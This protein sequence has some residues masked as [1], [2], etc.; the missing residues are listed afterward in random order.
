[1]TQRF[2]DRGNRGF[3]L[4]ETLTVVAIL[5]ILL[6]ISAVAAFHYRDYLKITELDNAAR[7]IYMA[8]ENRA[9][10]LGGSGQLDKALG[11]DTARPLAEGGGE[12]ESASVYFAKD[13]A[14]ELGLLTGDAI[15]RAL[16]EGSFYIVYDRSSGAV[17]DVFYTEGPEIQTIDDAFDLAAQGRDARMR[18]PED[19]PMLGYYGGEQGARKPY[20]PLPAPEVMV[21]IHNEERLTVDV[22]FSVPDDAK[23]AVAGNW[24]HNSEQTVTLDCGG[25]EITLLSRDTNGVTTFARHFSTSSNAD[26]SSVTYTWILDALDSSAEKRHFRQ[27]FTDTSLTFGG[28][29]TVTAEIELSAPGRRPTSASGSDTNNSLFAERS[30]GSVARLENL[31]HLQNLDK[32]TSGVAGKTSAVQVS[33]I[34]CRG[35]E[36]LAIYYPSKHEFTPIENDELLSFDAGWAA[37]KTGEADKETGEAAGK[38]GEADQ[39]TKKEPERRNE[40]TDLK[41]TAA[42]ASGKPGAGLFAKT[43]DGMAFTGV[44]L[45]G[46]EV[47]AGGA[48]A[49]GSVPAA[50]ALVGAAGSGAAF[51]DIRVVNSKVVGSGPAGGVAG[52]VANGTNSFSDCWVYWEPEEGQSNLRS[53]LGSD[54]ENNPYKFDKIIR[55]TS[56]GGL[57]GKLSGTTTI[58]KSL[59]STLVGGTNAGGLVG[60]AAQ[61]VVVNT[62]YADCYLKGT[63]AAAGLLGVCG[64]SELSNVYTAGFI[65][66]D[67]MTSGSVGGIVSGTHGTVTGGNV[68]TAVA[69]LN[70]KDK[71]ETELGI[72]AKDSGL[73]NCYYLSP[74]ATT[75]GEKPTEN[76]AVSYDDMSTEKLFDTAMGDKFAFKKSAGDTHPYNLQEKEELNPPYSFPGLVG[77]P[78]YGDWRAYFK[79]PSLVYYE[80]DSTGKVGFSGGNARE[81]IGKLNTGVKVVTDGYAV[82]LM[83]DDLPKDGEFTVEYTYVGKNGVKQNFEE[84]Y[85]ADKENNT[86][87]AQTSGATLPLASWKRMEGGEEKEYKYWLAPLPEELVIGVK[88]T[89]TTPDGKYLKDEYKSDTSK[90]FYQYLRIDTDI[91]LKNEKT[92]SGEYFYNPHFAETVRPYVPETEGA[93]PPDWTQSTIQ[94]YITNTLIPVGAPVSVS[95]R[96]PRHFYHLSQYEDYY[97]NARLAFQQGLA[98]DGKK[99]VYKGYPGLLSYGSRDFQLQSPI[100]TQDKPFLGT[101]NGDSLPIRRL[102]FELPENEKNRVSAGLFGTSNGRLRNIVYSLDPRENPNDPNE[103][104]ENKPRS[105]LFQNS[106]LETYLGAL[107][108]LNGLNGKIENCAV[109]GVNLTTQVFS[110][111]IY[112]GGLCGENRGSI[113]NSAAECARLH[114]EGSNYASAYVGGLTGRNSD[115]INTSYA[116]GCLA[117]TASQ[118]NAPAYLAGFV[119]INA[120]S[121]SNSYAAMHLDTDGVSAQARGFCAQTSG[122][123]QRKTFYLNEGNFSYRGEQFL[124][125]YAEG[126]GGT[127]Q[128]ISYIDL[129]AADSPVPDMERKSGEG[130]FPYPTGVKKN[131]TAEHY[132][133]WPKPLELGS[134]GVYYWEELQLPGKEGRSYCVSLLAVNPGKTQDSPKTISKISTLS[135]AHDEGGEVT[136]Y[137]YGVYNRRGS[138][139]TLPE[140]D[141][142]P[143]TDYPL[144]YAKDAASTGEAFSQKVYNDL[145]SKKAPGGGNEYDKQVDDALAKLMSYE[146]DKEQKSEFE[147]HSFHTYGQNKGLSGGDTGGLYPDSTPTVP[148]G[149]LTLQ[150]EGTYPQDNKPY[151]VTVN[152]LLNPLFAEAL[153]VE[154]PEGWNKPAEDVPTFTSEE[155]AGDRTFDGAV[156]GGSKDHAYGVRSI[157][158]LQFI[159]WNRVNRDTDTRIMDVKEGAELIDNFPYLSSSK[160]AKGYYW[161]QSYDVL[162]EKNRQSAENG[163]TPIAE[164]YDTEG[165]DTG[166]L[167]G[168]FGGTYD[169]ATYMIKDVYVTGQQS[170]CAGLFGVVY[171]GSLENVV[172]YSTDGK[173]IITTKAGKKDSLTQSR[174]FAMGGL[175]GVAGTS[176][177]KKNAIVNC[178]IAGYTILAEVYTYTGNAWGGNNIGGMVGSSHMNFSGCSAVTKVVVQNAVENDNMRIGGLVGSCQGTLTNCYAGGSIELDKDTV[179]LKRSDRAIYI[180]GLVGGT[181]MKPLKIGGDENLTIGF[182][183]DKKGNV[184]NTLSNCYSYVRLPA[185]TEA[186]KNEDKKE[187]FSIKGMFV[188]G[189]AGE[190]EPP[191]GGGKNHGTCKLENCYYLGNESLSLVTAETIL[192]AGIKTD[193]K[194]R[195][196]LQDSDRTPGEEFSTADKFWEIAGTNHIYNFRNIE[197]GIT[198]TINNHLYYRANITPEKGVGLFRYTGGSDDK[199]HWIYE[200]YGWIVDASGSTWTYTTDPDYFTADAAV[201]NL[202]YEQLAGLQKN[203]PGKD[204]YQ[205]ILQLLNAGKVQGEDAFFERVSTETEDGVSVPGKYSYPTQT[206]PELRDRDYPFPTILTKDSGKYRVHYGDWPLKGFRRQTLFD[207]EQ[208]FS[209]LGGSPIEIDLFV[210]GTAPHKEYLVL[211]DGVTAGGSWNGTAW[212]SVKEAKDP[213]SMETIAGFEVSE[214]LDTSK[215]VPNI[216]DGEKGKAYYLLTVT[217]KRDGTDTLYISYTYTKDEKEITHTLPVIVHITSVAELRPSRL[218]MFPRDTLDVTVKATDKAGKDLMGGKLILNGGPNCGD[219]GYLTGDILV[220]EAADGKL[221]AIRFTTAVPEGAPELGNKLILGANTDFLYRVTTTKPGSDESENKDYPGGVGGEMRIEIIRPWENENWDFEEVTMEDG[222][223]RVVCTIAFPNRYV[224]GDE[225]TLLFAKDGD[226]EVE[227]ILLMPSAAWADLPEN[228]DSIALK[229]TYPEGVKSLDDL[230]EETEVRLPLKL[231][232]PGNTGLI[233]EEDG[234]HHTLTLIVKKPPKAES[235]AEPLVI[236]ALPPDEGGEEERSVRRRRAGERKMNP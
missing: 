193:L 224:V 144:L 37:K 91:K 104:T 29:F 211:T 135:T 141:G 83:Q 17:T 146:L 94:E 218:F 222:T 74:S 147:F 127:A 151:S 26:H 24:M 159:D 102:A 220:K 192:N 43:K 44:R 99:D 80:Q 197:T 194:N 188:V 183:D 116:V 219:S 72:F 16:L 31:R 181:Y 233:G 105:I 23:S 118:D 112:I 84:T 171:N 66:M 125:D 30:G 81:L 131:G 32:D 158:Q 114:V 48:L 38:T 175:A 33:D 176:D 78:H 85:T 204:P 167:F 106:E 196:N 18:P 96:T 115:R 164:Y 130:S 110:R 6:G 177:Q 68:Y 155:K 121:I 2:H 209:L 19:G 210:N 212:A 47:S 120:G 227:P 157:D 207:E 64:E 195:G 139:F 140:A 76:G 54:Q 61:K 92:A 122:G 169:G 95:V 53:L 179:K 214:Q 154:T 86:I 89:I 15:D 7:D 35:T 143:S 73:E 70:Q 41:V 152:F 128:P 182:I 129:T 101:Y 199:G 132:G 187:Y 9:V 137:G 236:D 178:S 185:Y 201:T 186:V 52:T 225:G 170:S 8:A 123:A 162:G 200:F 111:R 133:D 58:T 11:S 57:A 10:L 216:S 13:Q 173:G 232:S 198:D 203:I 168:W 172:L 28:D 3:S 124:A 51:Q 1:M 229:L 22:T 145:E 166:S 67:G 109:D 148:N 180:G 12:A 221:P 46:A 217:P 150:Q 50:G 14:V 97:N 103:E 90:D 202:T 156:P 160:T 36:P 234:Q 174:W 231:T 40:I 213:N 21:V 82:A 69:Y 59:A 142:K 184:S 62:S 165:G 34:N 163:Y 100:G 42:S 235:A 56:A 206:R 79:E 138:G 126:E 134:M 4:V 49:D 39:E 119:G 63:K 215:D 161:K 55:G 60:E 20:T 75:T 71:V 27:L 226:P 190:I 98:L 191:G 205:N 149:T 87:T 117:A 223:K 25:R 93:L 88:T 228:P 107:V 230:P 136:R 153:A 208:K 45:I 5:V 77:L 108:G 189:G 65:D 113:Q